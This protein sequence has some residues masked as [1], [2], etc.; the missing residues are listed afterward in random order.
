MR[1]VPLHGVGVTAFLVVFQRVSERG[2]VATEGEVV[3]GI[4][5][6]YHGA[7]HAEAVQVTLQ[8]GRCHA[9]VMVVEIVS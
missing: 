8:T 6:Q 5:S 4:G 3:A 1:L 7:A 2:G 9:H